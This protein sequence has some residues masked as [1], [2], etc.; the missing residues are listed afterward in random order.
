MLL[1]GDVNSPPINMRS[2]WARK[3]NRSTAV[4]AADTLAPE[5]L[6]AIATVDKGYGA[7]MRHAR[8]DDDFP[9]KRLSIDPFRTTR[10]LM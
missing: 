2:I 7:T 10:R 8:G 4:N 3:G 6:F 9:R 1:L 5:L